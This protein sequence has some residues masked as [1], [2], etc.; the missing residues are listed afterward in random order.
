VNYNYLQDITIQ[1]EADN[2]EAQLTL[3]KTGMLDCVDVDQVNQ[4]ESVVPNKEGNSQSLPRKH[5][6][7]A[8]FEFT[9]NDLFNRAKNTASEYH[10]YEP[11]CS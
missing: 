2:A 8:A 1:D 3:A 9:D 6:F 5:S 11:C 10:I 4:M 7:Q